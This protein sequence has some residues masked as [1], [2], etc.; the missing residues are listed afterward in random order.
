LIVRQNVRRRV[1]VSELPF[2]QIRILPASMVLMSVRLRPK[3]F[4]SRGLT[5]TRTAGS[6]PPPML[7]WP[8]PWICRSRCCMIVEAAS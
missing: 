4:R 8:T 3:L 1:L 5:S 6:A 7:T 2:R